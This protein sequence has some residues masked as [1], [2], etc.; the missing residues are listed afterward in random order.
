MVWKD[1]SKALKVC[2]F[3][4]TVVLLRKIYSDK[5]IKDVFRE[6]IQDCC[7]GVHN[8]EKLYSNLN[9]HPWRFIKIMVQN[10]K[11]KLYSH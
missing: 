5:I 11:W 8:N 4:C 10:I 6:T 9:Y 3:F 7:N 2:I 1:I